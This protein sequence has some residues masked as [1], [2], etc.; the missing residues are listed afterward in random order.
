M[1]LITRKNIREQ[2]IAVVDYVLKVSKTIG[3]NDT[4]NILSADAAISHCSMF[5]T[6]ICILLQ[7]AK[8]NNRTIT[9]TE[10]FSTPTTTHSDFVAWPNATPFLFLLDRH[11]SKI[12]FSTL[13]SHIITTPNV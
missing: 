10:D 11:L 2:I 5:I 12:D 3:K 8:N 13:N 7:Y 6:D 1:V 9:W 4:G